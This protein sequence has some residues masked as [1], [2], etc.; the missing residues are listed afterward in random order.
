[1]EPA[2][3]GSNGGYMLLTSRS[4]DVPA[5]ATAPNSVA[6]T[7][8]TSNNNLPNGVP[9]AGMSSPATSHVVTL[10]E[11][12]AGASSAGSLDASLSNT[13]DGVSDAT[14][15]ESKEHHVYHTYILLVCVLFLWP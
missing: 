3:S 9:I 4:D 12:K 11:R 13:N 15:L 14:S 10:H 8:V 1:M 6:A 2:A 5:V 7:A